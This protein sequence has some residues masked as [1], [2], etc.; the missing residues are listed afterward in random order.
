MEQARISGRSVSAD[1]IDK[2][3]RHWYEACPCCLSQAY[4]DVKQVLD[5][6][7]AAASHT[8]ESQAS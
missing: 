4:P 8:H 5:E 3:F 7:R 1:Q 6:E 2:G